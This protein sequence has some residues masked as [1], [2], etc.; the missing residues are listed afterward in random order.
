VNVKPL[1]CSL[2]LCQNPGIEQVGRAERFMPAEATVIRSKRGVL[3][4]EAILAVAAAAVIGWLLQSWTWLQSSALG[5]LGNDTGLPMIA[6][7]IWV[8]AGAVIATVLSDHWNFR[9]Q[10][11]DDH[12]LVCDRLGTTEVHYDNIERTEKLAYGAGIV[13]KDPAKWIGSFQGKQSGFE[14]LC[15]ASGIFK[16]VYGCDLCIK[17]VRIDIGVDRFIALLN[18][19][20][21]TGAPVCLP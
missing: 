4:G 10:F 17:T 11:F 6:G 20:A 5:K 7:A 18:E 9:I 13:L 12:L 14:K 15:K 16:G 1:P 21:L 3:V 8:V 19:R 2:Q